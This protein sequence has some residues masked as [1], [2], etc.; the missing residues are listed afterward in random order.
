MSRTTL[1]LG[2]CLVLGSVA[3]SWYWQRPPAPTPLE[4][5][6]ASPV[7]SDAQQPEATSPEPVT[8]EQ[9]QLLDAPQ[10]R[11]QQQRLAFHSRY[12]GFIDQAGELDAAARAAEAQSLAEQIEALERQGELALSEALL[13][14]VALIKA[15][16][17][18][19][20]EQKARGEALIRRYQALSAEREARLAQ[21]RDPNFERYKADE[22]R[23]VEEVMA[24]QNIPD[25]L[26]RDQYLRQRLQEARERS[27]Q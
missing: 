15:D 18:D 26:S 17:H 16:S 5:S 24:L 7:S 20:A 11:Q 19:Q 3:L 4:V 9:L 8:T 25:G 13:L 2:S 6:A 14:E 21:R 23:I 1:L 27:Y 22:Q 10:V 12:R